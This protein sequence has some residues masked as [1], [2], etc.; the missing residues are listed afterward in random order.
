TGKGPWSRFRKSAITAVPD[1]ERYWPKMGVSHDPFQ[2]SAFWL[3]E[4]AVGDGWC[5]AADV[6]YRVGAACHCV[7]RVGLLDHADDDDVGE[8]IDPG[9]GAV[10]SAPVVA[11]R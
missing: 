1:Y 3:S 9:R 6:W 4:G 11:A 2:A 10:H 7:A 8:W 5:D